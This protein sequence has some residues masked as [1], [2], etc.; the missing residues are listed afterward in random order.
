MAAAQRRRMASEPSSSRDFS[1]RAFPGW[2]VAFPR[3]QCTAQYAGCAL[4]AS[5]RG[6]IGRPIADGP[7]T[8]AM[9]LPGYERSV[10]AARFRIPSK[11]ENSLA[12]HCTIAPARSNLSNLKSI[13]SAAPSHAFQHAP[14]R[15]IPDH[16]I[17]VHPSHSWSLASLL[18]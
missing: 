12:Q 14:R 7:C 17:R 2:G 4:V 5:R 1:R 3:G 9:T 11:A 10:P 18:V 6:G 15:S 13:S 16:L 8:A